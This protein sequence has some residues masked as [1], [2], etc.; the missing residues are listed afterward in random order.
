MSG[1]NNGIQSHSFFFFVL[2]GLVLCLLLFQGTLLTAQ[3]QWVQTEF[4]LVPGW[5]AIYMPITPGDDCDGLFTNTPIQ[6]VY[7]WHKRFATEQYSSMPAILNPKP[8][9]WL[10][11]VPD[12]LMSPRVNTMTYFQGGGSYLIDCSTGFVWSV[13]GQP[14]LAQTAWVPDSYNL[15]GF[16]VDGTSSFA[17]FLKG[18]G[19]IDIANHPIK[20]TA[21]NLTN[22]IISGTSGSSLNVRKIG[23]NTSY[24]IYA[25]SPGLFSSPLK[26]SYTDR[27]LI[28]GSFMETCPIFP[29]ANGVLHRQLHPMAFI[30]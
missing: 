13:T 28:R 26:I 17:T 5:N 11:W 19:F 7:K 8:D 16:P 15:V 12:S 21:P 6:G 27:G 23:V 25:K 3:A 22:V 18:V 29:L 4:T 1:R 20:H 2:K 24:W 30:Y 10:S 14:V 9:E